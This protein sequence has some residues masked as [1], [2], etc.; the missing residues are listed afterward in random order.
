MVIGNKLVELG[1]EE[2]YAR[3]VINNVKKQAPTLEYHLSQLERLSD[4]FFEKTLMG[5]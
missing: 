5:L 4:D 3:L 1:M 2:T